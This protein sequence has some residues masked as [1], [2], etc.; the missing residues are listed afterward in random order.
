MMETEFKNNE[1]RTSFDWMIYADA[2]FAGLSVLIPIPLVDLLFETI[3]KRRMVQTIAK[4]ND[5][6]IPPDIARL[7]NR[8]QGCWPGCLMWPITLTL[9]FLKRL[10]RTI[11]YF[12]TIKAASDQLSYHWHRAFLIDFMIRRGDLATLERARLAGIAMDE[13]LQTTT[14][15]PLMQL[16]TQISNGFRHVSRTTWNFLRRNQ[17]DK[18]L[19][20]AREEMEAS[21]NDFSGYLIQLAKKYE[22]NFAQ[23]DREFL[24]EDIDIKVSDEL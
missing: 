17:E 14:T 15:S 24:Q 23:L 13:V 18:V 9:E 12:L 5:R 8:S 10:Y 20:N 4:R 21:W 7:V 11:L 2:T 6:Q 16:A 1:P 22:A 3:F 19:I